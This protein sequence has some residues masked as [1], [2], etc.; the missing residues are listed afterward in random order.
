VVEVW[1]ALRPLLRSIDVNEVSEPTHDFIIHTG[2]H[3]VS[4][5]AF[6]MCIC[7]CQ[8]I[9]LWLHCALWGAFQCNLNSVHSTNTHICLEAP[10]RKKWPNGL[11]ENSLTLMHK[12]SDNL[13]FA[14]ADLKHLILIKPLIT[15]RNT[16]RDAS[17]A[18]VKHMVPFRVYYCLNSTGW[19]A[20]WTHT[21]GSF[22]SPGWI[23][24]LKGGGRGHDESGEPF[25]RCLSGKD[26]R[27]RIWDS[28][29][30][31]F[32]GRAWQKCV[33]KQGETPAVWAPATF[34][35]ELPGYD[36]RKQWNY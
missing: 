23:R 35:Q 20:F 30:S 25:V 3:C 15:F 14:G 4:V 18:Y 13:C 22:L 33:W 34:L 29:Y 19:I 21:R 11:S 9:H 5:L 24:A 27:C 1:H 26:E 36:V 6:M 2:L 7:M 10:K 32:L 12:A 28:E 17:I 16:V 31:S 8:W